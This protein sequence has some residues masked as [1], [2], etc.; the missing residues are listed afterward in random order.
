MGIPTL[1]P[2]GGWGLQDLVGNVDAEEEYFEQVLSR[3]REAGS[4]F[5][6]NRYTL[7]LVLGLRA[8]VIASNI[9]ASFG[10]RVIV[11]TFS[12]TSLALPLRIIVQACP[13][14]LARE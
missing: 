7:P 4:I 5:C 9:I 12:S 1:Q 10:A 3:H 11:A 14:A 2:T 6:A 8:F 13:G